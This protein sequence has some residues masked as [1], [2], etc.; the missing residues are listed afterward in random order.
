MFALIADVEGYPR[1]L[2]GCTASEML[3]RDGAE[4]VASLTVIRG[5]LHLGF[6][7]RNRLE[8]NRRVTME[9]VEGP[10]Q[11]LHGEWLI[12]PLG[13]DGCRVEL[14]VRFSFASKAR[15]MVLGPMF[16]LTCN[17]IVDAFVREARRLYG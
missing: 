10:F 8:P 14:R 2:P 12:T 5:P 6:T 7:T 11:E 15:D 13:P 3:E 1:F 4:V 16:E 9:L 17:A